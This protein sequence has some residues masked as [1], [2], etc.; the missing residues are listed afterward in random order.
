MMIDVGETRYLLVLAAL[1]L[2]AM[3]LCHV[4]SFNDG[5]WRFGISIV[6]GIGGSCPSSFG[7]QFDL[8]TPRAVPNPSPACS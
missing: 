3:L 5:R 8:Q 6:H 4:S 2:V 7:L 1:A